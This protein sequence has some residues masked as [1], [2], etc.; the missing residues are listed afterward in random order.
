MI[1]TDTYACTANFTENSHWKSEN[2]FATTMTARK[3]MS[4]TE[5]EKKKYEEQYTVSNLFSYT[6]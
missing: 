1:Y 2:N 6:S 4:D 5:T 3:P